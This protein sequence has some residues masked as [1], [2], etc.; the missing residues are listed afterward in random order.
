MLAFGIDDNGRL[1]GLDDPQ[2]VAEKASELINARIDPT[3]S[4]H[5]EALEEDGCRIV[6]LR[7]ESGGDCPYV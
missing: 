5:Q 6:L 4:F 2:H 1:T 3:P 7:V